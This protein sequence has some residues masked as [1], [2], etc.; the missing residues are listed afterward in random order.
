MN[1][2]V[3]NGKK[4]KYFGKLYVLVHNTK[5]MGTNYGDE[6]QRA[7]PKIR[8]VTRVRFHTRMQEFFGDDVTFNRPPTV[9]I[10]IL[11]NKKN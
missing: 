6:L 3:L 10:N 9:Q 11:Y 2:T 8:S 4:N 1:F 7:I 5:H